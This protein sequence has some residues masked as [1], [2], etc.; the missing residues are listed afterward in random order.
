M[1]AHIPI[2]A[3]AQ[4][5][6]KKKNIFYFCV[7]QYCHSLSWNIF[8]K[9]CVCSFSG[10]ATW[11]DIATVPQPKNTKNHTCSCFRVSPHKCVFVFFWV[12]PHIA[13]AKNTKNNRVSCFRVSPHIA[14]YRHSATAL[15]KKLQKTLFF[16]ILGVSPHIATYRHSATTKKRQ[17]K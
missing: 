13:T 14:T 3:L 7:F 8:N 10:T 11:P 12:L 9:Q 4:T 5:K 17:N 15:G 6:A 1:S 16:L 2:V